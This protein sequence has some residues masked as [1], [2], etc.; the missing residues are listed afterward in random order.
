MKNVKPR[1]GEVLIAPIKKDEK[2]AGG[3][4][5]PEETLNHRKDIG[6]VVAVGPYA[7]V[8][9]GDKVIFRQRQ[10]QIVEIDGEK[11]HL[12]ISIQHIVAT[13]ED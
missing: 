13:F 12:L 11:D 2:T 3:L 10:G 6:L 5:L 4:V 7:D 8:E 9:P 1:G